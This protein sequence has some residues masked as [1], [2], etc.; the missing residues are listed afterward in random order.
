[1]IGPQDSLLAVALGLLLGGLALDVRLL[2]RALGVAVFHRDL[3]GA[4]AG[5]GGALEHEPRRWLLQQGGD[6]SGGERVG[7]LDVVR[8]VG[9]AS[10]DGLMVGWLV[11]MFG[12]EVV[13]QSR[14][15]LR[16]PQ[17]LAL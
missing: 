3:V 13:W 7:D 8:L 10:I 11:T 15:S 4:H 2:G 16:E 1:M 14:G 17:V 6:L 9:E 12:D 5:L